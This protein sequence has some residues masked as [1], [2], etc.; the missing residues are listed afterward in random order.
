MFIGGTYALLLIGIFL[1][2]FGIILCLVWLFRKKPT[3]H[4]QI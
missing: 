1:F 4:M 3:H 2:C